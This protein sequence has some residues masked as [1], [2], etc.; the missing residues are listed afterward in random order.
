MIL[1]LT[2]VAW[3]VVGRGGDGGGTKAAEAPSTTGAGGASSATTASSDGNATAAES[4][5]GGTST[6]DSASCSTDR[7][8]AGRTS[9]CP[10]RAT[11]CPRRRTSRSPD[12]PT[13]LL[14]KV[15][16]ILKKPDLTIGNLEGT[17]T[18]RGARS[19]AAR[20]VR[21]LRVPGPAAYASGAAP[22]GLRPDEHR[23]QPRVRLRQAGQRTPRG[24]RGAGI[25]YTG[26][27]GGDHGTAR[28]AARGSASSASRRT[29][30]A[31]LTT[32][33][34]SGAG[35][36]GRRAGRLVVVAFHGGAEGADKRHVPNG[37]ETRSAR[38]AATCGRSRARRS[39]PAPTSSVGSGPHVIRGVERYR[40]R[41]IA[42][43][44]GNFVGW[45]VSGSRAARVVRAGGDPEP[46]RHLGLRA[47]A[48]DAAARPGLRRHRR[49]G[50]AI[51]SAR[52]VQG[53]YGKSA[54][55]IGDDGTILPPGRAPRARRP[56]PLSWPTAAGARR[57]VVC[58][59]VG[60][61]ERR[62]RTEP[63]TSGCSYLR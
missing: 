6:D 14:G 48:G 45:E 53:D 20:V 17:L 51:V 24:A 33:A 7:R 58:D 5:D 38:T 27:P 57:L 41:L 44:P 8:R 43:S 10:G 21:L 62:G 12:D 9:R 16:R 52:P 28:P 1:L 34:G 61:P 55:R 42:Y 11:W 2:G 36:D 29:W 22:R 31:P 3:A 39:T 63:V 30:A 40:G 13:V 47:D 59:A 50:A 54:A 26:A 60:A 37:R 32:C 46:G 49:P 4:T 25:A 15:E 56:H 35:A 23:Q 19:A 18:R